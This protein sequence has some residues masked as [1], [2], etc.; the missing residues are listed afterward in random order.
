MTLDTLRQR[1]GWLRV[2]VPP[3]AAL[4]P[5]TRI[6]P[7]APGWMTLRTLR[8]RAGWLQ[9]VVPLTA[10]PQPAGLSFHFLVFPNCLPASRLSISTSQLL[11][12]SV[13]LVS[14]PMLLALLVLVRVPVTV[15]VLILFPQ[16]LS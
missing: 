6:C 3:T 15:V 10:V 14:L 1:A 11:I 2:V 16:P 7:F 9:V 13:L 5:H 4:Q 12:W 8:Q